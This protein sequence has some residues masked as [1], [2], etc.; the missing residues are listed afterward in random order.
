MV[1]VGLL[2][3]A[4]WG[5]FTT[6]LAIA[7]ILLS[8]SQGS[9]QVG[10]QRL[11]PVKAGPPLSVVEEA[12]SSG[13]VEEK[14][15]ATTAPRGQ[16]WSKGRGRLSCHWTTPPGPCTIQW[17]TGKRQIPVVQACAELEACAGECTV[18]ETRMYSWSLSL[19]ISMRIKKS[20]N[21]LHNTNT[22]YILRLFFL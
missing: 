17:Q 19:F 13:R 4:V 14:R 18:L 15:E 1:I 7:M 22:C 5:S 6:Q 21:H 2:L 3:S 10:W 12:P 9:Y 8:L 20:V 16:T 11:A